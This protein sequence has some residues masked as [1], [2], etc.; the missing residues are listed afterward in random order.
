[1]S[2]KQPFSASIMKWLKGQYQSVYIKMY[3][4]RYIKKLI[5]SD[6]N[7][8]FHQILEKA[9]SYRDFKLGSELILKLERKLPELYNAAMEFC[10]ACGNCCPEVCVLRDVEIKEGK[11]VARCSLYDAK[12]DPVETKYV[13]FRQPYHE[14]I[15]ANR[16][17]IFKGKARPKLCADSTPLDYFYSRKFLKNP[18]NMLH[19]YNLLDKRF[20][21]G[22]KQDK[23]NSEKILIKCR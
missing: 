4:A 12:G 22:R 18:G 2:G 10:N 5:Q 20:E 21:V 14:E 16:N 11:G 17:E 13:F 9:F 6:F 1:M 15:R 8:A 3:F 19:C 23:S 7:E